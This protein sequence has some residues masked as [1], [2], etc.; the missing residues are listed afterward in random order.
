[1][2]EQ[3]SLL[4]PFISTVMFHAYY[5]GLTFPS[6]SVTG[7]ACSLHCKHCN[8]RY[9]DGMQPAKTPEKLL[10]F[11][12]KLEKTGGE[13]FLLSG[14]S[15]SRGIVP[16][17]RYTDAIKQIKKE[18][19]LIIN[20]HIGFA[21]KDELEALASAGVDVFSVD[22]VGQESTVK[23]VYGLNRAEND[24]KNLLNNLEKANAVVVPHITAGLD[25]GKVKGECRAIDL[26]SEYGHKASVFLSLI[27]TK[28]TAMERVQPLS[29]EEFLSVLRYA[30]KT[31][32]GDILVGCMR[33]RHQKRWEIEAVDMGIKGIVIPAGSTLKYLNEKGVA[34]ERHNHCCALRALGL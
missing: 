14:G 24:Y 12:R 17:G 31:L 16:L 6:V 4:N 19:K 13:G 18:T 34:V 3:K 15:D 22:I 11:A 5:P 23:D 32:K 8:A 30:R 27:P 25:F 29:E 28:G 20:A 33:P 2:P 26:I 9:L 10:E 21:D 7:T 1:M